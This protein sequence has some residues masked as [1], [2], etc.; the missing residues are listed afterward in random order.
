MEIKI[1][2]LYPDLLNLFGDKG[3]IAALEKRCLWRDISAEITEIKG[4][5]LPDLENC[6]ILY[7]G[8]GSDAEQEMVLEKLAKIKDKIK[9]YVENGGVILATCGG[10]QMLGDLE[11]IDVKHKPAQKRAS[12]NVVM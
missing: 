1:V 12:G 8:G 6:D 9:D 7:I 11:L 4:K 5:N 10:F 2:H 3:N